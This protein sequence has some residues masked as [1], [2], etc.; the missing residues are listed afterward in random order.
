MRRRAPRTFRVAVTDARGRPVKRFGL[1][2]WLERAAPSWAR[3][4]ATIALVTDREIRR[5]NRA[6]RDRDEPTD[7]LSFPA[8][9]PARGPRRRASR[10]HGSAEDV[11]L[12]DVAIACGVAGRQ[13]RK[14]GHALSVEVRILA[15]HGLLHLLGYDHETDSGTMSRYEERLR[16][17][18]GLPT[19]LVARTVVDL[20]EI[21]R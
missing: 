13:A 12:G 6:F 18:A 7:V 14:L 21:G 15:L 5:L 20:S 10:G 2:P 16:R 9:S 19:G 4:T 11:H 1:A 3:G 8:A 17:R